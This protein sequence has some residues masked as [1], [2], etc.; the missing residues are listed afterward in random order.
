MNIEGKIWLIKGEDGKLISDIDT[1]QIFHNKYLYITEKQEM[2]KYAFGNLKGWED[3]PQKAKKGDIIIAGANFGAGSSRQ[4]AVDCF[5]A[6]GIS[7]IIA[8]SFGA[9]YKRNAINSGF[10]LLEWQDIE[11]YID[12]FNDGDIIKIS[13]EEGKLEHN[14]KIY[15]LKKPS[16][17][18][19]EILKAG[20]LFRVSEKLLTME[21]HGR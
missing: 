20:N 21:N 7:A 2:A 13:F 4:Q 10:P 1:D 18:Q 6:L 17:V 14:G 8:A 9:I 3:F 19:I 5:L 11:K 16:Y 12:V 15:Q